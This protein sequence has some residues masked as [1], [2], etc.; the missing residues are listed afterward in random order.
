MSMANKVVH[1]FN[2]TYPYLLIVLFYLL[3]TLQL[4]KNNFISND[5]QKQLQRYVM[6]YNYNTNSKHTLEMT[7][8][9]K[10]LLMQKEEL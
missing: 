8:S 10:L 2:I 1:L 7:V 9:S 6:I 5:L 4:K 3:F